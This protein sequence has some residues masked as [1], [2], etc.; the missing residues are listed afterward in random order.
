MSTKRNSGHLI[1]YL[2]RKWSRWPATPLLGFLGGGWWHD[3]IFLGK[4]SLGVRGM[5]GQLRHHRR[6]FL[7]EN[8]TEQ[9]R[10]KWKFWYWDISVYHDFYT[11]KDVNLYLLLPCVIPLC[12]LALLAFLALAWFFSFRHNRGSHRWRLVLCLV[13][14]SHD[15]Y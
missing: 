8:E 4:I 13:L 15:W 10:Y 14:L 5:V 6:F 2:P 1:K 11:K 7:S 3:N 9:K 12:F